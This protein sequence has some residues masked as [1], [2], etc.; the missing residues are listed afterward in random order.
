MGRREGTPTPRDTVRRERVLRQQC[1]LRSVIETISGELT[2]RPLLTRIVHSACELLD[3]HHA[4]I[5]LVDETRN[6]VRTEAAYRMPPEE[7]GADLHDPVTQQRFSR[8]RIAQSLA[9]AWERD[10]DEGQRR[11]DRLLDLNQEALGERVPSHRAPF[12]GRRASALICRLHRASGQ[13][14]TPTVAR[15]SMGARP[16]RRRSDAG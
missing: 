12:G 9:R 4:T 7:S 3:A 8:T 2:L 5:G 11:T 1:S 13:A 10:A 14:L 15:T 16:R 6:V